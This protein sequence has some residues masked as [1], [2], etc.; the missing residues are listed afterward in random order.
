MTVFGLW[1]VTMCHRINNSRGFV[2]CSA[3][4]FKCKTSERGGLLEPEDEGITIIR[5][6]LKYLLSGTALIFE[7][8]C[9]SSNT[10]VII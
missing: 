10:G 2:I 4:N 6:V 1:Y 5:N 9:I 7:K 8:T 3:F